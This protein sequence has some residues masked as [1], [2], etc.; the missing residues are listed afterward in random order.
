MNSIQQILHEKL[1]I[2]LSN[3]PP[4]TEPKFANKYCKDQDIE[5]CML[6]VKTTSLIFNIMVVYRAPTGDFNLFLIRHDDSIKSVYKTNLHLIFCGDINIDYLTEYNRKRQLVSMLQMYNLTAIV[7][8]ATRL[9]GVSSTMIENIILDTSKT[10]NY[11][12]LP[13]LNGLSD[14]DA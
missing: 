14:H 3:F 7:N 10:S 9:Q 6:Y 1:T 4:Y 8:F 5:V 2:S 11:T 13:F 12:V